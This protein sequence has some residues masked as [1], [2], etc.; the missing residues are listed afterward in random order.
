MLA[1]QSTAATLIIG[2]ILDSDGVE[3]TGAVI[4]DISLSKNGGTLT[5]L[6]SAAS[7][8][9]I[10]NGQYTL[11][12]TTGNTDTL[13][14]AQFLC[15]KSTYQMPPVALDILAAD[16]YDVL[17]GTTAL[18][19]VSNITGGTI[20]T[21]TN[22]TTVNGL[23]AGV[24]TAASI[25]ADAITDAKVASDVTIASV[26]GAVGS[27][28]TGGISAASFAA[29]AIDAAAIANG[30]IDAA[31]FA[32]D[33]DAEIL[34]YI[35]DDAT[36][37][38]ASALN[39][40]SGTTIPAI[41]A[42]TNELQTDWA[43]GGRL[44]LIL[45]ARAS[46]A[47]VDDLPTNSELAT[48]L[49]TADD[50]VLAAIAALNDPTAAS[51]ADAVWDETLSGHLG[52]G[53]TGEALNAAGAAG[54]P[55]TTTLPGAY[56]GSQAG[57]ILA[58]LPT[59]AELATALASA[60]DATL[61]AIAALNNLSAA[62][63]NAEVDTALADYDGPTNTEMVAAFTQIKGATWSTTDTLEAIRDRGDAAWV[64]ATGFSTL[65]EAGVRTAVGLGSANLDTQLGDIPT[66]AELATS[67]AAADDATLAAIAALNN[68]SAAQVNA[69][70]DT[71]I[72]DANLAT[73][74]NLA[75]V[76]GYLDT[77]IAAILEDTGTTIPALIAALNDLSAN[78]ILDASNGVETGVTLR[79][80]TRLVLAAV[81]GKLSGAATN[82]IVIRDVNDTVSRIT[83]T[84]DS[85]GNRSAVTHNVS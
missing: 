43:N 3:Y 64:T 65:D 53:S 71:A 76:A 84:V 18:A 39:T 12:L 75:T 13:G 51:I 25:A 27:V 83:A 62:Q 17:L 29:G 4:G 5:A 80:A 81:A 79:Q 73:A 40:A 69:E 28:A 35:V 47:S 26:T 33:V 58:D 6:A 7:L 30:A 11:V 74:A 1:K 48:A 85:D 72:A 46:Q 23:A 57:A 78:D 60:D 15:N 16:V 14:R 31:T 67:Q 56:T 2:P 36:R 45:D 10:A 70:V 49:G 77:E 61:A 34:S 19:T 41:V 54:D 82:T 37:I 9:H 55:W 68:L 22:V 42:D 24:I 32:A 20:T 8:T 38:D 59:N 66:N 50:A 63:V 52:A 44:D 21:A